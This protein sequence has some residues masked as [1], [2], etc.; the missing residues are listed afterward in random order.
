[1]HAE[2]EARIRR[3]VDKATVGSG[4]LRDEIR[5]A[6]P[7]GTTRWMEV[8]GEV[9]S[10]NQ[11]KA[12]SLAGVCFGITER[13]GIEQALQLADH[14]NEAF[15][16]MLA[17]ELRNPLAPIR[18]A[19]ELLLRFGAADERMRKAVSIVDRQ[20]RQLSR[21]VYDHG[22]LAHHARTHRTREAS[23]GPP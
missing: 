19:S 14:R 20:S 3:L 2:D 5:V 11:G 16:A 9:V 7:D 1:M 4:G 22:R 17:H 15:L 21:L 6:R 23:R 13:K 12:I 8:R 18:S 10:D